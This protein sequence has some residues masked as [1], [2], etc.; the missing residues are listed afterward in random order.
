MKWRDLW[1]RRISGVHADH[2]TEIQR[3]HQRL[4]D[5]ESRLIA[6]QDELLVISGGTVTPYI[7]IDRRQQPRTT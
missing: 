7:G 5:H 6:L 4:D 1:R 3:A 2:Q